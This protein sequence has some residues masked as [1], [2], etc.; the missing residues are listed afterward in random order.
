MSTSPTTASAQ[1]ALQDLSTV[2]RGGEERMTTRSGIGFGR[3]VRI[4]LRK[5][6]DTRSGFWL[7]MSIGLMS[8][9]ATLAVLIFAPDEAINYESFSTA[10]GMPMSV[11][12]PVIAILSITSEWTQRSGLT[13]FTLVPV[14][15]RIISAKLAATVI[16]GVVS[17]L[18]AMAVGAIG[19]LAGATIR[20]LD[21]TWGMDAGTFGKILLA[22]VLGMLMGFVLG[23][24]IRHSAGALVAFFAWSFVLPTI[25][26]IL[27]STQ[28]WWRDISRW[29]D[30]QNNIYRL[31]DGSMAAADW[32]YLG[33]TALVWLVIPLAIGTRLAIRSE[34]K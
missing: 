23:A 19:N 29:V 33:V 31:Y 3:L 21:L 6:F 16:I 25:T 14:R 8:A 28:A 4:E 12:L 10:I 20:G 7:M 13:T 1:P 18:L 32:G 2:G 27:T 22:N 15:G 9:L 11:L 30:F 34:V 5:M 26:G 17:M 24:L